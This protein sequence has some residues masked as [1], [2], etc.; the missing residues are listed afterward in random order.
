M[1]LAAK[2]KLKSFSKSGIF[3][4][5]DLLRDE[6]LAAAAKRHKALSRTEPSSPIHSPHVPA[7]SSASNNAPLLPLPVS[8]LLAAKFKLKSFSK[9]GIFIRPDLSRDER[10][11]AA[12]KRHPSRTEPSSHFLMSLHFLCV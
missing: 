6:R 8:L 3:I 1:L 4:R 2:F 7:T 5:P 11:A 9:S 10:L 12:A